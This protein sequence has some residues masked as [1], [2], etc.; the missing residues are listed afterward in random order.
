MSTERQDENTEWFNADPEQARHRYLVPW[1]VAIVHIE[2]KLVGGCPFV[3]VASPSAEGRDDV[4]CTRNARN[5]KHGKSIIR[6]SN[7]WLVWPVVGSAASIWWVWVGAKQ[8]EEATAPET[9]LPSLPFLPL[10][11]P[12][13]CP[14]SNLNREQDGCAPPGLHHH[15]LLRQLNQQGIGGRGQESLN[16]TRH[17]GVQVGEGASRVA[18]GE[19]W[20]GGQALVPLPVKPHLSSEARASVCCSCCKSD[21]ASSCMPPAQCCCCWQLLAGRVICSGRSC[22]ARHTAASYSQICRSQQQSAAGGAGRSDYAPHRYGQYCMNLKRHLW[23]QD[24][25]EE[26]S[27]AK[28]SERGRGG[29]AEGGNLQRWVV[30]WESGLACHPLRLSLLRPHLKLAEP[31]PTAPWA[32]ISHLLSVSGTDFASLAPTP[33]HCHTTLGQPHKNYPRTSFDASSR[34]CPQ[35][36]QISSSSSFQRTV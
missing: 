7:I 35:S 27:E 34:Y 11:S 22:P 13:S 12:Q 9:Q 17:L 26:T 20:W 2:W 6:A 25:E 30:I 24:V 5:F 8:Q 18:G 33:A 1:L 4:G 29:A 3:W 32:I 19:G 23:H 36:I 10:P 15:H 31:G 16:S 28:P 21:L 14:P